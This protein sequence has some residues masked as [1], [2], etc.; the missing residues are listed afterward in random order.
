MN[1][2]DHFSLGYISKTVGH[3]GELL[4]VLDVDD[5]KRYRKL[6]SV[7]VEIHGELV[8]FFITRLELRGNGAK[9]SFEGIDTSERAEELTRCGLYL[10]LSLLPP[11][12]GKRF[13]FH[14][15][16]G[17]AAS[18][19]RHGAIGTVERCPVSSFAQ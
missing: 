18:D 19:K 5:P 1:R 16:E 8:P 17:F 3:Q 13:Y 15:V 4:L 2:D 7:F 6:E 9:V 12:K 14:E 11:L 10:P